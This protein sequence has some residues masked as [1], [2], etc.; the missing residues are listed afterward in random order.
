MTMIR[1][2]AARV[3][4]SRASWPAPV[5]K[6]VDGVINRVPER[7]A[8][9]LNPAKYGFTARDVPRPP[10]APST[11]TRVYIAPVNFSGQGYAWAR[12]VERLDGVGAVSMQYRLDDDFGFPSDN[13]LPVRV[14]V[15]ST[16][17]QRAQFRA[18]TR[19]FTHVIVEAERP[20]FGGLFDESV[21]REVQALRAAGLRVAMLSH[22]SDLRLP[23]RHRE[24]DEW[25]PF[26]D[27]SWD[28]IPVLE[29]QA[30][31]NR[32]VLVESHAPVFVATPE[33]LLDWPD[34]SW[35]PN[36]VEPALWQ[37]DDA[38]LER[39]T[40]VVIHAPSN[41]VIKGT[42]LIEPAA[43]QLAASGAIEYRRIQGVPATQMPDVYRQA[44]IV[45]EQF[46]I[47]NYSTVALQAMAAGRLVIGHVHE[48][49]RDHVRRE[50]GVDVPIVEAT[51]ATL[52]AVL[53]EVLA[54]RDAYRAVAASGPAFI[55]AVHNG[56][57]SARVLEPF[58]RS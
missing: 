16:R 11:P 20:I 29:K 18:V 56:A 38:A 35:L 25:S 46:R 30:L 55:A 14:F 41:P 21:V 48:Q 54:K 28:A 7:I 49:V 6:A 53:D 2:F 31:A 1:S 17:W 58:L 33:Q 43:T 39:E 34:A 13:A 45:L 8:M 15:R 32:V 42:D 5:N 40:P 4:R 23:S 22:G 24:L 57:A 44:D 37:S 47:G 12:A 3:A 10:A 51:P 50:Y 26:R 52:R 9:R 27:E 19:G 36:V